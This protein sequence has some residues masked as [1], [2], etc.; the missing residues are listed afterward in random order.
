MAR[1][2]VRMFNGKKYHLVTDG[3]IPIIQ[4]KSTAERNCRILRGI[5]HIQCRLVKENKYKYVIYTGK[6]ISHKLLI[7][8]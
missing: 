7:R 3:F 8:I 4:G 5:H 2:K 1:K 6:K